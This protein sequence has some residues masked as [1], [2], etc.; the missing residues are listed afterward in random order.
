MKSTAYGARLPALRVDDKIRKQLEER[1]REL[2]ISLAEAHRQAL[3]AALLGPKVI[4]MVGRV[5]PD[6]EVHYIKK[7]A[8]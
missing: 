8:A 2:N 5:D 4:P 6:G 3:G 1:A 7:E